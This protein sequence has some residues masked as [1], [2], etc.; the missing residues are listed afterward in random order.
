MEPC[1]KMLLGTS[2]HAHFV[3]FLCS[4]RY[5]GDTA[6]EPARRAGCSVRVSVTV[7]GVHFELFNPRF[8]ISVRRGSIAKA[9][10]FGACWLYVHRLLTTLAWY[11][12]QLE[13]C[14]RDSRHPSCINASQSI[15]RETAAV[16]W[17]NL[18]VLPHQ[19]ASTASAIPC[20]F[21]PPG[22]RRAPASNHVIW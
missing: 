10:M 16:C 5:D 4:V 15:Q 19:G 6:H 7:V 8:Q 2:M 3:Y 18:R 11:F 21:F 22:L 13:R 9:S 17:Q 1:S 20:A 14:C 12:V